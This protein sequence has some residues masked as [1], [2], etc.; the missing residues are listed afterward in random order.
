MKKALEYVA[1]KKVNEICFFIIAIFFVSP[2]IVNISCHINGNNMSTTDDYILIQ[3]FVGAFS[4]LMA[5]AMALYYFLYK[6]HEKPFKQLLYDNR[7]TV[8]FTVY[9][10]L[11]LCSTFANSSEFAWFGESNRHE[12]FFVF[13]IYVFMFVMAAMV[14]S[15][16][17]KRILLYI[18]CGVSVFIEI[19]TLLVNKGIAD[20]QTLLVIKDSGVFLQHNHYGYYLATTGIAMA[21]FALTS[22]KLWMK[23]L[24]YA[25]YI[26][27]VYI[28]LMIGPLGPFLA[29]I[30]GNIFVI[31]C[32][33]LSKK[34]FV[35]EAIA[36]LLILVCVLALHTAFESDAMFKDIAGFFTDVG[37][38][39]SGAEDSAGAGTA[40]WG[41]WV[42][43]VE[44]IAEK[45][46][47][48]WGA[49]GIMAE[50][51]LAAGSY[52]THN[53]FL[54]YAVFFGIPAMIAYVTAALMV[55]LRALK[56]RV[57]LTQCEIVYLCA[58]FVYL[59]SS[60]FG[61]TM[62]YT[63][64]FYYLFLGLAVSKTAASGKKDTLLRIKSVA[65]NSSADKA[66]IKSG[67]AIISINGN[68]IND[69]L[70]YKFYLYT[71]DDDKK[72]KIELESGKRSVRNY[73]ADLG[74]EF[75]TYLMDEKKHCK[76]NCVFCFVNQ[77]PKGLRDTLYFKDDDARLSFLQGNYITLTNL[78]DEDVE[79]II[80]MRLNVNVSV[81]TTNPVL[82]NK[83]LKNPKAGDSLK[84]LFKMA[85]AGIQINCQIVLCPGM[86]DGRE[87][88]K[89]LDDLTALYPSVNSIA[90]VPV[91]LTKYRDE[92]KL[93]KL[94][95]FNK[96]TA[97]KALEI[98][99]S[100]GEKMLEQH[101]NRTVYPSDELFIIA[102]R[103]VPEYNYYTDF[104]QYEN[105][106]GMWACLEHEFYEALKAGGNDKAV[107]VKK[108]VA[109]G[110]MAEPLI[111]KL[112]KKLDNGNIN[113][114]AVKNKFFGETVSVSGLITG[115]D[116]IEQ[117]LPHK[118]ELGAELLIPASMLKSGETVFLDDVTLEQVEN[119][120][121]VKVTAVGG[122]G[123]DLLN[124][125][126]N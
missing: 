51:K 5:G 11:A 118:S 94:E 117:L 120:L 96:T 7:E 66:E 15:E 46:I 59:V 16:K 8:A 98:I 104:S 119:K 93:P 125:L 29:L 124:A 78:S 18:L 121:G 10:L 52:I 1:V 43:T 37:K 111:K 35:P 57:N 9:I 49:C 27:T 62:Y 17:I 61:V 81:H 25:G 87:L 100:A 82:R 23:L 31:I 122:T 97:I 67:D 89:T 90:C 72:L 105:G 71:A 115:Q 32:C 56:N 36:P 108:S 12:G 126:I 34:R 106:V 63:T 74:L 103:S 110:K 83:M 86:N 80:K 20:Y 55:F 30:A 47:L 42:F 24:F 58:A 54:Q 112:V 91:G 65:P 48:G 95:A 39:T 76:N 69:V 109:T 70:D 75:E 19:L 38:V 113:V 101:G 77:L 22:K 116:L 84:Y 33:C 28:T 2:V 60:F 13:L 21:A 123:E 114:Y 3:T 107:K 50:L 64:P 6:R 53:E 41:L 88:R 73:N 102:G 26:F 92:L 85:E 4:I 40:R 68:K 79:R 44:K 14:R 99:E 45:P